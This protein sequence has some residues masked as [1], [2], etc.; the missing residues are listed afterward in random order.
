MV[1]LIL[2]ILNS[3]IA[4]NNCQKGDKMDKMDK[5]ELHPILDGLFLGHQT[6]GHQTN[7]EEKVKGLMIVLTKP[8][9]N[10]FKFPLLCYSRMQASP[11]GWPQT[12]PV[13]IS[14]YH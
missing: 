9:M 8:H 1:F 12:H 14:L 10:C 7:L 3:C 13:L 11:L 5:F 6:V 2:N 4:F